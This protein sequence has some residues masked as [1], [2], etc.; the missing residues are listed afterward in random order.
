M[1]QGSSRECFSCKEQIG[2]V[3]CLGVVDSSKI[4]RFPSAEPQHIELY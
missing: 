2:V 3:V 1:N 4:D